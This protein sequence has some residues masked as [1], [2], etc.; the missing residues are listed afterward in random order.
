MPRAAPN[1][2]PVSDSV[3]IALSTCPDEQTAK[4]IAEGLVQERLATCVNRI[5]GVRST[6]FW[7]GGLKDDGEVL[8]I[9]KTTQ[10]R[11]GE[12]GSR[13]KALHPYDL[14]ELIAIPAVGGNE[15]YLSWVRQGVQRNDEHQ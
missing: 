7:D 15:A 5:A 8:L 3:V 13:L 9:I 4:A 2:I 12:L 11:L 10:T 1:P 6:Y 14:P